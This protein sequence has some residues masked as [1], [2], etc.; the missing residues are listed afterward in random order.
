MTRRL[1]AVSIGWIGLSM[2]NDAVP[3]VLLPHRVLRDGGD[4]STLGLVTFAAIA[5]AALL[6]P[7]AGAVSDR[8][9]RV[10]VVGAGTLVAIGGLALLMLPGA[11]LPAAVV[12]LS[13]AS[14][15]QAGQQALLPDRVVDTW[16]GRAGGL[17]GAFDIGGAF[18]AFALLA[19]FLTAGRFDLGVVSL[20]IAVLASALAT[21]VLLRSLRGRLADS[22][23]P[24]TVAGAERRALPSSLAVIAIGRFLFLLGIFAVGRFLLLFAAEVD[25]LPVDEAAGASSGLLAL[26][27][28]ATAAA[29]LPAGWL[30]DHIGRRV[31]MVVGSV[32][33]GSG[34]GLLASSSSLDGMF[35][36]GLLLAGGTALFGAASWAALADAVV[37]HEAG[38]M[39][40]LA[41]LGTAGAA[42]FAGLLGPLI[43]FAGFGLV[44]AIA[45]GLALLGGLVSF[46]ASVSARA[47][48]RSIMEQS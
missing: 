36:P 38:R 30:S 3:A 13:G 24:R 42:A 25:G 27:P 48:V 8:I 11:A 32:L 7:V 31:P 21:F 18:V 9:G 35:L 29:S 41:N 22:M 14:I 45:A 12:A 43:D 15:A 44:F 10:P 17:K 20:G 6:Q 26:L 34:I 28:L 2:L 19:A 46:T 33:A 23:S 39:L 47:L 37:P 5:L 16:R 40:G 1:L 4:A